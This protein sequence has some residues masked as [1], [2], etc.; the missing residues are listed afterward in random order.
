M[1][2]KAQREAQS[3]RKVTWIGLFANL[4]LT[5]IKFTAGI[6]GR[7]QAIIADAVHSLSDSITDVAILVG[8]VFWARPSDA[9]HPYGHRRIETI[10]TIFIGL[11]LATAGV[12]LG[13]EGLTSMQEVRSEPPGMIAFYAACLSIVVK[14]I[15]Y[16]W[17][18][19]VGRQV[20]SSALVANAWHHR[21]D[22]ISSLPAALAVG[23]A[24]IFPKWTFLDH[25]G[26]VVV[27]IFILQAAFKIVWPGIRELTESGAPVEITRQFS[28]IAKQTEGVSEVH[29]LRSRYIGSRMYVDMHIV[30]DGNLTVL[31]GNRIAHAVADRIQEEE[32]DVIDVV[33]HV[34][35]IEEK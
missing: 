17:T 13:W 11:A 20:K 24:V 21:S 32:A 3:V 25:V 10:I 34:D 1:T 19:R 15:L 31:E 8:S 14:E 18:I 6:F 30:V 26:A 5:A 2:N 33:V 35:P 29:A 9:D 12:G 22:A 27:S 23:G 7:S 28:R 16:R 4:F